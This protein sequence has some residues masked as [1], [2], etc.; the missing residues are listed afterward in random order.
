MPEAMRKFKLTNM[1]KE[2]MLH[3]MIHAYLFLT[4]VVKEHEPFT[5][6]GR[7]SAR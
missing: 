3:S 7:T 2:G 4:E 5:S 1:T 6:T